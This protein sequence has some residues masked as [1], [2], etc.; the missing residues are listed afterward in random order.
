M[1]KYT[2]ADQYAD[3]AGLIIEAGEKLDAARALLQELATAPGTPESIR[4][5]ARR[6][7]SQVTAIRG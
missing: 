7:L 5:D 6:D 3:A 2:A 4:Q 1:D